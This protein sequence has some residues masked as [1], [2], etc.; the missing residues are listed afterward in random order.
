MNAVA[1]PRAA[2]RSVRSLEIESEKL[3]QARDA[4]RREE[5]AARSQL[6]S[7]IAEGDAEGISECRKTIKRCAAEV[8]RTQEEIETLENAVKAAGERDQASAS[9]EAYTAI[10]RLVTA[11]RKDLEALADARKAFAA[12]LKKV[13]ASNNALD[14]LMMQ[15]GVRPD[16][17]HLRV[18]LMGTVELGLHQET[19]GL[20]GRPG[21]ESAS[22]L[23]QSGRADLKRL[24]SEFQRLYMQ[25]VRSA[26][27][28]QREP[29]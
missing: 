21:I 16:D 22:Q 17:W 12:A 28:L 13:R 15:S 3:E 2:A 26:L 8:A 5:N 19:D 1:K 9:I 7:L 14:A 23:E 27:H 18:L 29:D 20:L 10:R 6:P 24:A 4:A 25:R 11:T